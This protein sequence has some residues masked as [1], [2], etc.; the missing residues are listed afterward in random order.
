MTSKFGADPEYCNVN[1][2]KLHSHYLVPGHGLLIH[3]SIWSDRLYWP[4]PVISHMYGPQ[5]LSSCLFGEGVRSGVQLDMP[6]C[7]VHVVVG[8][9]DCILTVLAQQLRR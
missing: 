2:A 8:L 3:R 4:G 5:L 6:L 1:N 9:P 7:P